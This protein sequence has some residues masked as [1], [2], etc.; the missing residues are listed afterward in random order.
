MSNLPFQIV[1]VEAR[2]TGEVCRLLATQLAEHHVEIDDAR[3][4]AAVQ[5]VL[6]EPRRGFFLAAL[7]GGRA[8]AAAYVSFQWSLEQGGHSAWLEELY[9]EPARRCGGIGTA[10]LEAVM[11]E[12]R[13]AG[14]AAIDLE[15]D[16]DHERVRSLYERCGFTAHRRSRMVKK[17]G[18]LA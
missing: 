11:R 2:H 16:A 10:L 5:G 14:C 6:A 7:Q 18:A 3:L 15:I 4:E 17:L 12:C 9:V 8:I 13:T 1:R